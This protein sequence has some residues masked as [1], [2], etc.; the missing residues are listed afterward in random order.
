MAEYVK[1]AGSCV[2]RG[3][4]VKFR[5]HASMP[6]IAARMPHGKGRV[7]GF[8]TGETGRRYVRVKV[9]KH[10]GDLMAHG[11]ADGEIW[12][13]ASEITHRKG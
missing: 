12:L 2:M 10:K 5:I 3:M 4:L 6:K 13:G 8:H 1:L 11:L 9:K 7:V